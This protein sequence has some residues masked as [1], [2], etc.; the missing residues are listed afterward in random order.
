MN[1]VHLIGQDV[2]LFAVQ[3]VDEV[4]VGIDDTTVNGARFTLRRNGFLLTQGIDYV[5]SFDNN[6]KVVRFISVFVR[7]NVG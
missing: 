7:R 4:G 1:T 3:L 5:F 6:N 2:A